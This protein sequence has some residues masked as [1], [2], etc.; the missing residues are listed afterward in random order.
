MRIAIIGLKGIPARAGGVERH[1]EEVAVRMARQGHEVTAYVRNNYTDTDLKQYRGVRLVHLPS[2]GTKHLDAI[3]HTLFAAL[4]ALFQRYDIV[5]FHSIGPAT[6]CWIVRLKRKTRLIATFHSR[7]YFHRKWGLF[8]RLFL[9]LGEYLI[10]A[11]PHA[12]VVLTRGQ[13]RYVRDTYGRDTVVIPNGYGIQPDFGTTELEAWGLIPKHYILSVC[14]L[15]PHKGIHYLIDAF[16]Q[17]EDE[18][19]LPEDMRLVIAGSGFHT[20]AYEKHLHEL[21]RGRSR[22]VFT[23]TQT[24][25][26]LAQ[27]YTHA[28]VFVQPSDSEGLSIALLEAMGCGV[29]PLV[30][31]IPEN[32]EPL[33]GLG[34]SFAA[35]SVQDLK[36]RLAEI[37]RAADAAADTG[38]QVRTLA[39]RDYNWDA[40]T[41]RYLRL[42]E[43]CRDG[44]VPDTAR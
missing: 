35:G 15:I 14:R 36:D 3:S 2:I 39:E 9:R 32:I 37:M 22:I 27:L 19:R 25:A 16:M 38:R 20:D 12:T 29:A 5:H 34:Y 10:C 26:A 31:S 23:G 33:Q 44:S 17:L 41:E 42:Y 18:G 13:Q 43:C 21:A 40:I 7:D 24:G 30:S 1:V 6:L 8:A 11:V 4:H 28:F